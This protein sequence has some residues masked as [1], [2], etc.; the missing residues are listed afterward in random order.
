M[1]ETDSW[2]KIRKV[3]PSQWNGY[4]FLSKPESDWSH[5]INVQKYS[6]HNIDC[7]YVFDGVAW[8]MECVFMNGG[9]WQDC[10]LVSSPHKH[11]AQDTA[12]YLQTYSTILRHYIQN[13][14]SISKQKHERY[15][16]CPYLTFTFYFTR[17][18]CIFLGERREVTLHST[19]RVGG[20]SK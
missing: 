18:S 9:R 7:A 1:Q 10:H 12:L 8:W 5:K 2:R 19:H 4:T 6:K 16:E 3:D 14:K 20:N 11:P 13:S 17:S 15:S